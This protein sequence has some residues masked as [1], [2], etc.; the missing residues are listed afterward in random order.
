MNY[1][2]RVDWCAVFAT[3][4]GRPRDLA[5]TTAGYERSKVYRR[6]VMRRRIKATCY[7]LAAVAIVVALI[8]LTA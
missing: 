6:I 5:L 2:E 7:T 8:G 4:R 1:Q 3:A